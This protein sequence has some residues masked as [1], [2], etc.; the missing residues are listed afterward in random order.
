MAIDNNLSTVS[1]SQSVRKWSPCPRVYHAF[2]LVYHASNVD[3]S[4]PVCLISVHIRENQHLCR[5]SCSP[6]IQA[7][8]APKQGLASASELAAMD[9]EA[10][11]TASDSGQ[12]R[13]EILG[14]R[15]ELHRKFTMYTSFASSLVLMANTS[16]ITGAV[17]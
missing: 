12:A 15:Q 16:G 14:Y 17:H 5:L 13:L 6:L 11:A 7:L 2:Y 10:H 3:A 1:F 9:A 8:G 4:Q